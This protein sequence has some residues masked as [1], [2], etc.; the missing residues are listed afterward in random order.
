MEA[1]AMTHRSDTL[2]P[3]SAKALRGVAGALMLLVPATAGAATIG[4]VAPGT[5]VAPVVYNSGSESVQVS[6]H[7]RQVSLTTN[8]P[9]WHDSNVFLPDGTMRLVNGTGG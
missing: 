4:A 7:Q 5:P 2:L 3:A 9:A 1:S 8:V 6:A